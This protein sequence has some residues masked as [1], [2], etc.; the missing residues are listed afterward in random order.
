MATTIGM[1]QD[2][3]TLL[4]E[5]GAGGIHRRKSEV[6]SEQLPVG[7]K[8]AGMR[9]SAATDVEGRLWPSPIPLCLS[10]CLPCPLRDPGL[11]GTRG[12]KGR[13]IG[14]SRRF[15][16]N[17]PFL[18]DANSCGLQGRL[19]AVC[20]HPLHSG[21]SKRSSGGLY[22]PRHGGLNRRTKTERGA[23]AKL[24][25]SETYSR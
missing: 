21:M 4:G 13:G 24:G 7:R 22:C 20:R 3:L 19:G 18:G 8:V 17:G 1:G 9:H 12:F 23:W 6:M 25:G 10:C 2:K 16:G 15:V 11:F 5:A 14:G